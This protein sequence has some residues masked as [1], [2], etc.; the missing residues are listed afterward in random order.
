[1]FSS[2]CSHFI[3][4]VSE[5]AVFATVVHELMVGKIIYFEPEQFFFPLLSVE[6]VSC[7]KVTKAGFT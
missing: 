7:S 2:A 1:M 5:T 3:T 4:C 6:M